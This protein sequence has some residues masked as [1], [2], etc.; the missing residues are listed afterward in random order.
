LD[1]GRL[2]YLDLR[3]LLPGRASFQLPRLY[4][5]RDR[6]GSQAGE[7]SDTV[8]WFGTDFSASGTHE[9]GIMKLKINRQGIALVFKSKQLVLGH[10]SEAFIQDLMNEVGVLRDRAHRLPSSLAATLVEEHEALD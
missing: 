10:G 4:D 7:A 8:Q 6:Q 1:L 2:T 5:L 3:A 9:A